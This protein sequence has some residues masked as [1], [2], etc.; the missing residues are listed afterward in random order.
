MRALRGSQFIEAYGLLSPAWKEQLA[1]P[2]F[3]SGY[4]N[5]Q[6]LA[7]EIGRV[8]TLDPRR[9]RLRAELKVKEGG[10]EKLYTAIYIAILTSEGW[11]LDGGTF[12]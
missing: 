8:E 12:K 1:Y 3:E 2:T 4:I 7:F 9:I 5:T 6:V 10:S 11:R